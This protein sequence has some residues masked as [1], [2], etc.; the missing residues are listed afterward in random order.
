MDAVKSK[1]GEEIGK[2]ELD[3]GWMR[4]IACF[5]LPDLFVQFMYL[6]IIITHSL[7]TSHFT[8]KFILS[9]TMHTSILFFPSSVH[10]RWRAESIC[11]ILFAL[12]LMFFVW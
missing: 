6:L 7:A 9:F 5:F 8:C 11:I 2:I 10:T 12:N 3:K 1:G 4:K